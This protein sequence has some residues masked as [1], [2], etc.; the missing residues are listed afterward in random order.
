MPMSDDPFSSD[1]FDKLLDDFINS[2]I[3]ESEGNLIDLTLN[4]TKNK[5]NEEQEE[6]LAKEQNTTEEVVETVETKENPLVKELF[7]D[8]KRFFLAYS[9]FINASIN[10]GK[11]SDIEIPEFDLS[12]E[13]LLPRFLLLG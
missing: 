8:E 12:I 11:E 6:V 2:Q 7:D 3:Q 5:N 13:D 4:D 1:D 10:C 9:S